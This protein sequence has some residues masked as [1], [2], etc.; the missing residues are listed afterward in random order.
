MDKYSKLQ[1]GSDVRG[2][3]MDGIEG[4]PVN[5]SAEAVSNIASAFV[6]WL[7]Q[8]MGKAPSS[9]QIAVG[10]DSRLSGPELAEAALAG[11]LDAG[12][13]GASCGLASTPA[14]FM[15][16]VFPDM[17]FDGAI[18]ITASHLPWNRNGMK[19]FAK[20]SGLEKF[21]ISA[22]L[23]MAAGEK[24]IGQRGSKRELDIMTPYAAHLREII[25]SGI[26]VK[27][28]KP[29]EGFKIAVDAGN[30][31]GGFFAR[32]VLGALGAD[33]SASRY[34][35]PDGHFPN[36]VPNPENSQVMEI[37]QS[38]VLES[39]S[40][41]GIVFDTDVDRSAA[42]DETG[43][44]LSRNRLIG[45]LSKIISE[46]NPGCT[47]VTDSV[48]SDHLTR[49]IE[50][51]GCVH[52]RFKRGYRNVINEAV[53]LNNEGVN[54]PLAIET[55]GHC[56]IRDNYFLDDGAYV[57]ALLV[58]EMVN[59]RQS[60]HKLSEMIRDLKDPLEAV[61]YRLKIKAPDFRE[62]GE[63]ILRELKAFI[64]SK[65]AWRIAPDN[66]EGV[67]VSI[68]VY[69]GWFL[70]RMSLH[71]PLMPLNIESDFPGGVRNIFESLKKFL[72][73]FEELELPN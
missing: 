52:H 29:L 32:D 55:S 2:V 51:L 13:D 36:H 46:A 18:M 38:M 69:K 70:L 71:D 39:G 56:A 45:L 10:T 67:R 8:R 58:I 17:N 26:K 61:E 40:D 62:Y 35:E 48:T 27:N 57:A 64:P 47:I 5:L 53:R 22:I 1:N 68:P 11:I 19:F 24:S 73:Q 44:I 28:E 59:A 9:I 49:Y 42:V 60:N 41:L 33:I 16:T 43:S 30:G 37:A 65:A 31:S 15:A 7:G 20:G 25:K 12:A 54:S 21:D 72:K 50:G 14:M 3:A 63:D 34:L 66:Y 23:E 6:K 4:E